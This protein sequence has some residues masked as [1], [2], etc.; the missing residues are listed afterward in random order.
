M[1]T[2]PDNWDNANN[3]DKHG[4]LLTIL[5]VFDYYND[6]NKAWHI[7]GLGAWGKLVIFAWEDWMSL[8]RGD[9]ILLTCKAQIV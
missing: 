8:E 5:I 1:A 9:W 6:S 3:S 2:N 7:E 4:Q